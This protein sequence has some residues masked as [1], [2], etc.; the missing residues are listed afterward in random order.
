VPFDVA[1]ALEAPERM[2][3]LVIFGGFEGLRFDWQRL[4]WQAD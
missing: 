1:F 2:A 4:R 3:Y